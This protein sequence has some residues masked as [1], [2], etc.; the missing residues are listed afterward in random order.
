M[1]D[2]R[3][4][5]AGAAAL[6]LS[7]GAFGAPA[8]A[9]DK[10]KKG[11]TLRLGMEGGSASDLPYNLSDYHVLVVPNGF[12]NFSKPDGTGAYALESFQPGVRILTKNTGHYWKP[13]RAWYDS[14]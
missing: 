14:I 3:E 2:R 4:L 11:G 5:L 10:P 7:Y 9:D 6:G 1:L 8:F 12:T 13:N